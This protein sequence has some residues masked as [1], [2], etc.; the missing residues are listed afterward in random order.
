[1]IIIVIITIIMMMTR[2]ARN[3]KVCQVLGS[4]LRGRGKS[5]I[6]AMDGRDKKTTE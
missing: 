3:G 5:P 6:Y 4:Y 2:D 1:M